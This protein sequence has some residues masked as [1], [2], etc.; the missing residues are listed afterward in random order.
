MGMSET[1]EQFSERMSQVEKK[2]DYVVG[3][4][5]SGNTRT[6]FN[7]E[8]QSCHLET[9]GMVPM[10]NRKGEMMPAM[11]AAVRAL[12]H[13]VT[14]RWV[15]TKLI[16]GPGHAGKG[17]DRIKRISKH[18]GAKFCEDEYPWEAG[19]W[20]YMYF[21]GEDN[22]DKLMKLVWDIHTGQFKELWG[23]EAKQYESCIGHAPEQESSEL[24]RNL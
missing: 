17:R 16:Y 15:H 21:D 4:W 1:F 20:F 12:A 22:W 11:M 9:W 13:P 7:F 18:Y 6:I 3:P 19:V 23:D 10:A 8:G 5:H 24:V 2:A 14:D